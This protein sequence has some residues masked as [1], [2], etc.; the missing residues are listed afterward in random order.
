GTRDRCSPTVRRRL[1]CAASKL[2]AEPLAAPARSQ[3][4]VRHRAALSRAQAD[5][6]SCLA[7]PETDGSHPP[8]AASAS[9]EL[10]PESIC[11]PK[12]LV[13]HSAPKH[14]ERESRSWRAEEAVPYSKARIRSRPA[15]GR[16]VE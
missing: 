1:C 12:P 14:C 3:A 9:E 5:C 11:V 7:N 6:D 2:T 8:P 13:S 16:D 4:R 10:R 15:R